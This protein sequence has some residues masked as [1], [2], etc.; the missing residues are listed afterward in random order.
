MRIIGYIA[1]ASLAG[2]LMGAT[3]GDHRPSITAAGQVPLSFERATSG[4]LRWVARGV[5]YRLAVGAA[6]VEVG[7]KDEQLRIRF[8]GG[9]AGARSAGQDRLPGKVNYF[10]GSDPKAWLHDIPT[11]QRVRYKDVYPGIDMVWY[12]KQGRLEYDLEL[13]PGADTVRIA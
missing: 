3:A 8:V 11:Y 2:G 9:N 4:N 10:V 13:Q 1:L 6:D 12:G 5:G 7:L